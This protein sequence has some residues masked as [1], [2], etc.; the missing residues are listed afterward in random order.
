MMAAS[1]TNKL[2]RTEQCRKNAQSKSEAKRNAF[3]ESLTLQAKE[4]KSLAK[5]SVCKR[6]GVT[7]PFLRAHPDLLQALEEAQTARRAGQAGHHGSCSTDRSKEHII[8]AL[9]RQLHSKQV[10]INA[11]DAEIREKD[12]EIRTLLGKL[13]SSSPPSSGDLQRQLDEAVKRAE[14][15][16]AKVEDLES[17]FFAKRVVKMRDRIRRLE[18]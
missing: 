17:R 2:S 15:A 6:A 10:V 1:I 18:R 14:R 12:R 5:A 4:G 8:E 11:K 7:T 3:L 9:R 13:A 16:E